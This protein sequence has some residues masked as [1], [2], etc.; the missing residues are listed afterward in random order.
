MSFILTDERFLHFQ[1]RQNRICSA[2]GTPSRSSKAQSFQLIVFE[3]DRN[4]LAL[5]CF[6]GR[7][8]IA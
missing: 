6:V 2:I 7:F 1:L 3:P 5:A 8:A 4:L